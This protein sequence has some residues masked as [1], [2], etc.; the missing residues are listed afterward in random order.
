MIFTYIA[1][2]CMDIK[3]SHQKL[4]FT[5]TGLDT[6]LVLCTDAAC[7]APAAARVPAAA[8]PPPATL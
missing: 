6:V 8:E 2:E 4:T 3:Y 5:G 1:L 7:T